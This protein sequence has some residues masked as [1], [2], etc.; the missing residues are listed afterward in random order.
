[1]LMHPDCAHNT[2]TA[3]SL[4]RH[5]ELPFVDSQDIP[6]PEIRRVLS[7]IGI[8]RVLNVMLQTLPPLMGFKPHVDDHWGRECSPYT[9]GPAVFI[10]DLAD[11]SQGHLFK[12]GGVGCVPDLDRGVWFNQHRAPHGTVNCGHT[13]RPLLIIQGDRGI[14]F[15][16][17][18]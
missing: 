11:D 17:N 8:T 13:D 15:R 14:D 9:E 2:M 12:L 16:A 6:Q 1:M 3:W 10:W 18:T 4:R 5:A 7:A